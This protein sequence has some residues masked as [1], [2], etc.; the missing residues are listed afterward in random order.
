MTSTD[1]MRFPDASVLSLVASVLSRNSMQADSSRAGAR[2]HVSASLFAPIMHGK[3]LHLSHSS[4]PPSSPGRMRPS[5][6]Y[7]GCSPRVRSR[8]II[9]S[10]P[11]V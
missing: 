6:R 9:R 3:E 8:S 4:Q 2:P 5:G 7:D 10:M 1:T 11:T